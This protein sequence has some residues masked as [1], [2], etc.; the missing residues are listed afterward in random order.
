MVR[1]RIAR[2]YEDKQA[3]VVNNNCVIHNITFF[4]TIE[5]SPVT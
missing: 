5:P 2:I 3:F 4:A 1:S